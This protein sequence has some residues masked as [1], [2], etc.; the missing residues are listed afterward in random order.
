MLALT[1]SCAASAG[2]MLT[3]KKQARVIEVRAVGQGGVDRRLVQ[4]V[5]G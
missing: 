4:R 5:V 2:S 3:P 1:Q